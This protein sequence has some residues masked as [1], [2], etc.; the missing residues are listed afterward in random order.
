[1]TG[2]VVWLTGLPASG[3]STLAERLQLRLLADRTPAVL[4]DGDAVRPIL[5]A[6]GY[7]DPERDDFYRRLAALAAVL[8]RQ[9]LIVLVAATAP[10]R[11]HRETARE[12]APRYLEV[13]VRTPLAECE[14]RDPKGLYARARR[15]ATA[16][17]GIGVSYEPPA[18]PDVIADGGH[19]E[20]ALAAVLEAL[21]AG[22]PRHT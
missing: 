11:L 5:R 14:A 17:P 2:V 16:L 15:D 22:T 6:A 20:H 12:L 7:T 9:G 19:D 10:R 21:T 13:W 1:M 18:A 4:L 3:K 8:A